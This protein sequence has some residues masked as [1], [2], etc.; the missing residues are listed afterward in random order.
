[1]GSTQITAGQIS[2]LDFIVTMA[3]ND[4]IELYWATSMQNQA[5]LVATAAQTTPFA[6]PASPSVI[7]TLTP[8]S[9]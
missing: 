8:V 1:M 6:C 3:V 9:A 5:T 2:N 7:V 4:Y